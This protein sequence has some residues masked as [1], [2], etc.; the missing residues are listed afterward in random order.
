MT[1][2]TTEQ[3]ELAGHDTEDQRALERSHTDHRFAAN[4]R[5]LMKLRGWSITALAGQSALDVRTVC[6]VLDAERT[7]H[8][9]RLRVAEGLGYDLHGLMY[10][11]PE[12]I[13]EWWSART[14]AMRRRTIVTGAQRTSW[15]RRMTRVLKGAW[16]D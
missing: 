9:T 10:Q 4:V 13:N 11:R 7:T 2:M 8:N 16:A 14:E 1:L 6:R 5:H 12:Q 15:W 3:L